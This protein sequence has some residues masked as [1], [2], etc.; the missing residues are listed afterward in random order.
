MVVWMPVGHD[1]IS[2]AVRILEGLSGSVEGGGGMVRVMVVRSC[3]DT[4][5]KAEHED[6]NGVK[7]L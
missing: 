4:T 7:W 2:E 5:F 6:E 1:T 3:E